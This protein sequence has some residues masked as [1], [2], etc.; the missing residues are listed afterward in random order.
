MG[1]SVSSRVIDHDRVKKLSDDCTTFFNMTRVIFKNPKPG[2][3]MEIRTKAKKAIRQVAYDLC[4]GEQFL[5][6]ED[7]LCGIADAIDLLILKLAVLTESVS[8][9]DQ[10]QIGILDDMKDLAW[11]VIQC[12]DIHREQKFFENNDALDRYITRMG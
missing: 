10:R 7:V 9:S 4:T 2:S 3:L 1:V 5:A 12:V 6:D 8:R 11:K